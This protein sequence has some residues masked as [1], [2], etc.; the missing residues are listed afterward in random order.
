MDGGGYD[1]QPLLS[2]LQQVET[3]DRLFSRNDAPQVFC[4]FVREGAVAVAWDGEVS[5]CV[6]LMHS[7]MCYVLGREKKIKRYPVGNVAQEKIARIWE[8][9]EYRQF[10]KRV[11]EFDF[12]PCA[13]CSGC[14][15]S[16]SNEED[17]FGNPFPVCGDCLWAQGIILCP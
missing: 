7:Y 17:C 15:L 3:T 10:R 14:D 13:I 6:A 16:E 9:E 11:M 12:S 5:P 4:R 2:L 1:L 8:G